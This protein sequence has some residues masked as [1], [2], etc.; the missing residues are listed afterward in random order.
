MPVDSRTRA[1]LD[2]LNR[3]EAPRLHDQPLDI[4]RHNYQKLMFAYRGEPPEGV[5]IEAVSLARRELEGGPLQARLYRPPGVEQPPVLLW[6]HGGGWTLGD[7]AAYDVLCQKLAHGAG[8]AVLS[9]DYRLAPEHPFPA[10]VDDVWFALRWLVKQGR[11]LGLD[12]TRLAVGGDSAG[13]NLAA[14][15]AHFAR[16][17]GGPA[18]CLQLL[19]YPATDQDS[20]RLSHETYGEGYFLDRASIA[21]FHRNY[22]PAE[23]DRLDWRASPLRAPR[24][25]GLA[26]AL[27]ITAECDPLTDDACA[28]ASR[29]REAEVAVEY[30]EY[31]GCIHGFFSMPRL[32]PAAQRAIDEACAALRECWPRG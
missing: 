8:C 5:Q 25:E 12:V 10:A 29:L 13:G 22:L 15:L 14:V 6:L 11:A 24:F 3:I 9:L 27:I 7:L 19:V 17:A 31:E 23:A 18:L 4:A 1:L 30:S 26:P 16:D 28:Y 2:M 32:L 20:T 21:W